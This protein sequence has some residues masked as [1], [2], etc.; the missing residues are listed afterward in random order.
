M[1]PFK[2]GD[3]VLSYTNTLI[4]EGW[5]VIGLRKNNKVDVVTCGEPPYRV[6]ENIPCKKLFHFEAY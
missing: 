1:N 4:T 5:I 2:I 6:Y 3:R